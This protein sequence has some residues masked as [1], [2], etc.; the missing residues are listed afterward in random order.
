MERYSSVVEGDETLGERGTSEG[1][2]IVGG[3]LAIE[4][5]GD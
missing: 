4:N 1:N 5:L 3:D 2:G